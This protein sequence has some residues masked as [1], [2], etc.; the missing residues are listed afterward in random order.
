MEKS[1]VLQKSQ[2]RMSQDLSQAELA[3]ILNINQRFVSELE[4]NGECSQE[5][6]YKI[7]QVL[8]QTLS[9]FFFQLS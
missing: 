9:S 1:L 3:S 6:L 7:S 4:T 8:S 2:A 5:L